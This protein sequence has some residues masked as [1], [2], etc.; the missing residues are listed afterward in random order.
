MLGT[1]FCINSFVSTDEK[2]VPNT[3]LPCQVDFLHVWTDVK[4]SSMAEPAIVPTTI[5]ATL[6][7]KTIARNVALD[8]VI[9]HFVAF[10]LDAMY[11]HFDTLAS[12]KSLVTLMIEVLPGLKA[13]DAQEQLSNVLSVLWGS[14]NLAFLRRI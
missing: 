8:L 2:L 7:S 10:L 1:Q 5:L 6:L 13:L 4:A 12:R 11:D 14:S 3:G 9:Y